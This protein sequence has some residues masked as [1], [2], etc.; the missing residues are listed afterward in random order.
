MASGPSGLG[1]DSGGVGA[2]PVG[3]A[4]GLGSFD[5]E[6]G[7][8][9]G[10]VLNGSEDGDKKTSA[11]VADAIAVVFPPSPMNPNDDPSLVP[12]D[13]NEIRSWYLYDCAS[14][15][16]AA[17]VVTF[18][19][20]LVT[21]Y[22]KARAATQHSVVEWRE[23]FAGG[24][25]CFGRCVLA[26]VDATTG[27]VAT[28]TSSECG[29]YDSAIPQFAS[30]KFQ[31]PDDMAS[32]CEWFPVSP[33]IPGS[34]LDFGAVVVYCN[35]VSQLACGAFLVI[36]GSLGD[37][38]GFR[39]KGLVVGWFL[40]SVCPLIA[41]ATS[42]G[43]LGGGDTNQMRRA[44]QITASLF[45]VTNIAHLAAQQM[46]DAYLPLLA[47]THPRVQQVLGMIPGTETET[48]KKDDSRWEKA[49]DKCWRCWGTTS[50]LNALSAG[51]KGLEQ[52]TLQQYRRDDIGWAE[53]YE[54]YEGQSEET[55]KRDDDD[56]NA[57]LVAAVTKAR[58]S[59]GSELALRAPTLGFLSMLFVVSIQLVCILRAGVGDWSTGLR[60]SLLAVGAWG[61]A[62]GLLGLRYGLR[63][64]NP[65]DCLDCFLLCMEH[66]I[67]F[68]IPDTQHEVHPH[69]RDSR[70]TLC[71]FIGPGEFASGRARRCFLRGGAPIRRVGTR[72]KRWVRA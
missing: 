27:A 19:A 55:E 22:A 65:A 38:G 12:T 66:I 53:K 1:P 14:S 6:P 41:G 8:A 36:F 54:G 4:T 43:D 63:F 26:V 57:A 44:L 58:Q 13:A 37:F 40:F 18:W 52:L 29:A 35:F 42:P 71:F 9:K 31:R 50:H 7:G 64:P 45:V 67:P 61:A 10:D 48:K 51:G 25:L 3:R 15:P 68:P 72:R 20:M 69:S 46:F 23:N 24:S 5:R 60:L 70:L 2:V 56:A 59:S 39:K 33:N 11:S 62:V 17:T 16:V 34:G 21:G 49:K 47:Q 30:M 28:T 32:N